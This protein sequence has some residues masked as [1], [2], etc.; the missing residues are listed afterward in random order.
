MKKIKGNNE[1]NN[2][3]EYLFHEGTN[4]C[5]YDY[6]GAHLTKNHCT[7]RVWAPNAKKVFVTGDFC[8]WETDKYEAYRITSGGI[9]ECILKDIKEFDTYK[10]VIITQDD[11]KILKSDPYSFHNETRPNTA[12]KVYNINGYKWA[13]NKWMKNRL[14]H[15]FEKPINIY[16]LHFGS[17]RKY[18]DGNPFSYKKMAEELI[19][20]IKEMSYT[21]I[22]LMPMT[23]YPYDKSWGYQVTGYYA[24]T[25]RYGDPKD[26]MYFI[27][28]CHQN[29]IGVILDWVPAHFPKDESGLYEF[30]G[31]YCYEYSDHYKMEHKDWGTR[32][33]DYSKNE[34]RS[35]LISNAS[36][37][38]SKYHIDGIRVDAVAS[39]LYLDYG[40]N[41]GDWQHN[42]YG[43]N[44]NIEAANF[45]KQLNKWVFCEHKGIMMI[46]EESTAYPMITYPVSAGGLGFSFKW[47][48]G[49][50]NDS[51]KYMASDPIF[52]KGL[53]NN[54]TF[55]LTYAFSENYMLPLSH[56]EVVYGK[57]SLINKMPS[58]IDDKFANLRAYLAYMYAHPGK[59]LMFMGAEIGQYNEWNEDKELDWEVL[60][61]ELNKK[62]KEFV[63]SLN[64]FY[65]KEPTLWELDTSWDGFDWVRL[66]DSSNNIISF[67]R[68]DKNGNNMLIV[69]NFSSNIQYNYS[70]GVPEKGVYTE[71]FST[72][73][74]EF[75]GKGLSNGKLNAKKGE[76]YYLEL[77]IPAF[78]TIYLYN[79]KPGRKQDL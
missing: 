24:P 51:L 36:F 68:I 3:A 8:N 18:A 69:C 34:V 4:F 38:F 50:M 60:E 33:F 12:S 55:S 44:G 6:L 37:W 10:Y 23:E 52:R 25:S 40:R 49:W 26:F 47:N 67:F 22:E 46:A 14:E 53:H 78:S 79:K 7:F 61:N 20:Y 2:L 32:I 48:M 19:P 27:D 63:K 11:R 64:S 35:F 5:S 43:G 65:R 54:L 73:K 56:D 9:F 17:W 29:N 57:C 77:T 41:D 58:Y 76:K 70:I 42:E 59:K 28:M 13:D 16:E 31:S 21:H 15:P 71:V 62:H 1:N 39:M 74:E 75:G 30:D 72:D 66:D 45:L